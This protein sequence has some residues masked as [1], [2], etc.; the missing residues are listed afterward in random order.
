M[1]CYYKIYIF[2]GVFSEKDLDLIKEMLQ[3]SNE[4][5]QVQDQ[6]DIT[7]SYFI[8]KIVFKCF[9]IQISVFFLVG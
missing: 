8:I 5:A 1:S 4:Q 2:T 3:D 9:W 7:G 6:T